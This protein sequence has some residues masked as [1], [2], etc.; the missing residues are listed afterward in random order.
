M[1]LIIINPE[2]KRYDISSLVKD[3]VQLSSNLD[4]ITAQLDFELAYNFREKLPF[5][6]IDLE[7]GACSVELYDDQESNIFQGIIPK[8]QINKKS[9][10]FTAYDPGFYIVRIAD[11]FQFN[12]ITADKCIQSML[13]EF[14]MPVGTM[15]NSSVKIDE[16]YYKE[17]I[18]E[19]IK[20]IIETIREET[21]ENY[22]FYFKDNKFHFCKRNKDKY[23]EGIIEPKSYSIL[24]GKKYID[25][26]NF[27]KDA[28]FSM[29]FENM[30]NSIIVVDG[31]EDKMNKTDM[32]KDDE[33]IKKYGLL[34]YVVKQ[35]KNDQSASSKKNKKSSS[36]SKKRN[37]GKNKS[38]SKK[39]RQKTKT[40]KA[41]I[42]KKQKKTVKKKKE[43]KPIKAI[44]VL[45][46]K[47]KLEK[48]FTL[49]V[50][51]IPILRAGDLV[52]INENQT[53]IQGVFEVISVNHNFTQKYSL[54]GNKIYF[55]SLTLELIE[56]DD[57]VE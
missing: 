56:G 2:G 20:K 39:K 25:I 42:E 23:L 41:K 55:M 14:K 44:N 38:I 24:I 46:E 29:S 22:Y 32:A 37:N 19:I 36:N 5:S 12:N 15:E 1:K 18:Y 4:N 43:K 27:I 6:P 7:A 33:N 17:T 45:N 49:A 48:K 52:Q 57:D 16:Y 51:G 47:N 40:K 31:D 30:K 21:G 35:E 28:S 34:Q 26:F 50:P 9:P 8:V 13:N 54:Y 10:K 3:N 11:I 53:G